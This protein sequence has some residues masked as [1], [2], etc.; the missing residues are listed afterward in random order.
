VGKT[1]KYK[2]VPIDSETHEKLLALCD[3]FRLGQR[4]QGAMVRRLIE[5]E[6]EKWAQVKLAAPVARGSTV[7]G[8]TRGDGDNDRC[9]T[10][11]EVG[12]E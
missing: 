5:Q 9:W 10:E 11:K 1:T 3:A 7:S 12:N 4:G 2:M 6:Y 8:G